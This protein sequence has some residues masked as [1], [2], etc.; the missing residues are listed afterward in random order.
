[1]DLVGSGFGLRLLGLFILG[2]RLGKALRD[3]F[4]GGGGKTGRYRKMGM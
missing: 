2:W 1:M 3:V 4:I